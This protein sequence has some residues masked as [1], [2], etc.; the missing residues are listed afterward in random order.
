MTA[1]LTRLRVAEELLKA[2]RVGSLQAAARARPGWTEN[3]FRGF[4]PTTISRSTALSRTRWFAS[5]PTYL[6]QLLDIYL[7]DLS[8]PGAFTE[9]LEAAVDNARIPAGLREVLAEIGSLTDPSSLPSGIDVS[10]QTLQVSIPQHNEAAPGNVTTEASAIRVDSP[11]ETTPQKRQLF[12]RVDFDWESP[13]DDASV[14]QDAVTLFERSLSAFVEHGLRRIH[15]DAWLR[16]GCGRYKARWADRSRKATASPPSSQLGYAEIAEL[17]EIIR[18]KQNWPVFKP[19]FSSKDW[20]AN[21]FASIVPLRVEGFHPGARHIFAPEEAA[22]FAAMARVAS[23]YHTPTGDDI[24]LLWTVQEPSESDPTSEI[25]LT[26][27]R[28]LKNFDNLPPSSTDLRKRYRASR[29]SRFLAQR[30]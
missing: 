22:G 18:A 13:R 25:V 12:E 7:D 21:Q 26:S 3:V 28:I 6:M 16:K 11:N 1:P 23:C 15:G 17:E 9:R 2:V 4:R 29:T 30:I 14:V 19:Y 10:D 5:D 8:I 24:E 27:N 20:V